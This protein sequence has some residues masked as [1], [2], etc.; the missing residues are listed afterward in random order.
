MCVLLAKAPAQAE[1]LLHSLEQAA[2][3]IGLYVNANKTEYMCFNKRGNILSLNCSSLKPVEQFTYLGSSFSSNETDINSRLA[4]VWTVID[5]LSVDNR[6][7]GS[8]T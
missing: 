7:Y 2:A 5:S 4:K 6:S 1:T 3:G 8:L